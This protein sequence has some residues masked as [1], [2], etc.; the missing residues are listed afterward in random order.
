M[1]DKCMPLVFY[2]SIHLN[3]KTLSSF[4]SFFSTFI[5]LNSS[6]N[7]S[8]VLFLL[9][10]I[11]FRL[12]GE[13]CSQKVYFHHLLN[14][15]HWTAVIYL[16]HQ[17]HS[18]DISPKYRYK[19]TKRQSVTP[20]ITVIFTFKTVI[21]LNLIFYRHSWIHLPLLFTNILCWQQIAN[22]FCKDLIRTISYRPCSLHHRRKRWS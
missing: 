22:Y 11:L 17:I 15:P 18:N 14:R 2:S 1:S 4:C 3:L 21:S 13:G 16:H 8:C 9:D 6:S 19:C 5:D 20:K 10:N 12:S 7:G